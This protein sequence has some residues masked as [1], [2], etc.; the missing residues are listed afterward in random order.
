MVLTSVLLFTFTCIL[1]SRSKGAGPVSTISYYLGSVVRITMYL[2]CRSCTR[3]FS[4]SSP[5]VIVSASQLQHSFA[6]TTLQPLP[7]TKVSPYD[8][9]NKN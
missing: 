3:D 6:V 1:F 9:S 8:W 5:I 4:L 2:D 7:T